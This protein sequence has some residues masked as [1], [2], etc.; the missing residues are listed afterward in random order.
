MDS[1]TFQLGQAIVTSGER[2]VNAR[3][4]DALHH[5][6]CANPHDTGEK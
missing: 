1:A 5:V 4:D 2:H 3:S 6:P